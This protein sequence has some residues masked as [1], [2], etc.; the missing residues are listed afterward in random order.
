MQ[1]LLKR[2]GSARQVGA[3]REVRLT[4]LQGAFYVS[5][6]ERVHGKDILLVD[7]IVTT[8][9]SIEQAAQA[10]RQAGARSV[11]AAIFAKKQ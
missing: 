1:V 3:N 10:L 4:Q 2:L 6:P 7:D 9:G 11:A 8:G 5:R